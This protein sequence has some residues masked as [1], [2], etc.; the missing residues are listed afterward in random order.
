MQIKIVTE[1]EKKCEQTSQ[2]K[3]NKSQLKVS[4]RLED[5]VSKEERLIADIQVFRI[6]EDNCVSIDRRIYFLVCRAFTR[7]K[8]SF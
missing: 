3:C 5:F 8:T 4:N 7:S 1:G 6:L 2:G